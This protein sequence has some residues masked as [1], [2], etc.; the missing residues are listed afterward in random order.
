MRDEV[1]AG[2]GWK[3]WPDVWWACRLAQRAVEGRWS[4]CLARQPH[5]PTW[6]GKLWHPGGSSLTP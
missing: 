6:G 2:A 5:Q 3:E 4:Q 1:A